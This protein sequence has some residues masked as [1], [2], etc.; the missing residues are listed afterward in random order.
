MEKE[1]KEKHPPTSKK[2]HCPNAQVRLYKINKKSWEGGG[3][4]MTMVVL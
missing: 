4:V 1:E 3:I 2:E